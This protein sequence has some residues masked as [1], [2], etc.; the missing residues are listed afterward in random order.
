MNLQSKLYGV[1]DKPS[2]FYRCMDYCLLLSVPSLLK[3]AVERFTA[4]EASIYLS[5]WRYFGIVQ[6]QESIHS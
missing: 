3:H 5:E 1:W 6:F 4:K 2:C